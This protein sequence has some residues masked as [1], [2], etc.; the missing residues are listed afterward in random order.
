MDV[1]TVVESGHIIAAELVV[2]ATHTQP[3]PTPDGNMIPATGK[4]LELAMGEF[5]RLDDDGRII[6]EHRYLD[7]ATMFAQLGLAPGA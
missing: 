3:M 6:E 2:G 7:T 5:W 4:R 1:K